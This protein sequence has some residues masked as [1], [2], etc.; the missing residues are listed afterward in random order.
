[1]GR[2]GLE[3]GKN[4]KSVIGYDDICLQRGWGSFNFPYVVIIKLVY[5]AA[6]GRGSLAMKLV[7]QWK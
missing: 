6:G 2:R 7:R 4:T 5:Y 1:M 3:E